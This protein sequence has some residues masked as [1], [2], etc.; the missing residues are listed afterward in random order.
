MLYGL[1]CIFSNYYEYLKCG[2]VISGCL[3]H[4]ILLLDVIPF[5]AQSSNIKVSLDLWALT[6]KAPATWSWWLHR[7][8]NFSI[9]KVSLIMW[10]WLMLGVPKVEHCKH[11]RTEMVCFRFALSPIWLFK[12]GQFLV[13][14][15]PCIN[16]NAAI[17]WSSRRRESSDSRACANVVLIVLAYWVC[18]VCSALWIFHCVLSLKY[19]H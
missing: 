17:F 16:K 19:Q 5:C 11:F 8:K 1:S 3:R 12:W 4:I 13:S 6:L 7:Y 2:Q 9:I 18:Y 15:G 10:I 14:E